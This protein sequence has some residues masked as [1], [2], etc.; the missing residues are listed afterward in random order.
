MPVTGSQQRQEAINN[1][2]HLRLRTRG[3]YDVSYAYFHS[4]TG[5]DLAQGAPDLVS[6]DGSS[7]LPYTD[8]DLK[9]L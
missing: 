8:A 7:K 6:I 1:N 5:E 3:A 9:N 2:I 4:V